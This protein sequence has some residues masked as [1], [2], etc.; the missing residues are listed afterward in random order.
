MCQKANVNNETT[1]SSTLMANTAKVPKNREL[2]SLI[3][4]QNQP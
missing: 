1:K 3:S 4:H 2:K